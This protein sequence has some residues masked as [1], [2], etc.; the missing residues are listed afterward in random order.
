VRLSPRTGALLKVHP[1][2]FTMDG[3]TPR[4][5]GIAELAGIARGRRAAHPRHRIRPAA[6]RSRAPRPASEPTAARL[7]ARGADI[8]THVRRQAA[9]RS[10]V[11]DH[12]GQRTPG[13][14]HA[15][16]PLCR[17]LR[18][19]K[20][21]LAALAATL[22]LYLDPSA[23]L[24]EIPVL[25]MLTAPTAR[26]RP[27][28]RRRLR[29]PRDA[30]SRETEAGPSA[31]GG[32][33]APAAAL[34]PPC[35]SC[36]GRRRAAASS[37]A[38]CASGS[39]PVIARIVDDTVAL[40]L[41]TV[42]R[43][44]ERALRMRAAVPRR[45]DAAPHE[46]TA[47]AFLDRDGTIIQERHYLADPGAVEL[48]PGA[49]AALR[50]SRR[51]IR[52]RRRDEPVRHRP[53]P[54]H[55]GRFPRGA[56]APRGRCWPPRRRARRRVPLSPPPGRYTGRAS[57]ASPISACTDRRRRWDWTSSARSTSATGCGTY[58]PASPSAAAAS[59]SAPATAQGGGAL[60]TGVPSWPTISPMWR[61]A[62]VEP[63]TAG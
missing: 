32:G 33:A 25:R 31:V 48:L 5:V 21:T 46:R 52:A 36:C 58:C 51:R 3:A 4:S 8:V 42:D 30:A 63:V 45:A 15:R 56:G 2:N 55:G 39:P 9:G 37:S 41:R 19:D 43:A 38:G 53:G 34:H 23:A 7:A 47:A 44:D 16:N 12:A 35:W 28:A 27:T 11:R 60:P 61:P 49:A 59:W 6:R 50:R 54:V 29:T 22:R 10:A 18:V 24:R 62:G 17:A 13:S 26:A 57:A 1:S 14:T 40:D 20:L